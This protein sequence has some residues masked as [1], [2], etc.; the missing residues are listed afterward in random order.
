MTPEKLMMRQN[1]KKADELINGFKESAH[2][3][4]VKQQRGKVLTTRFAG[5]P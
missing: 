3:C 2:P 5:E 4:N 1:V